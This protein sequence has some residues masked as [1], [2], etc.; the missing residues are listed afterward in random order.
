LA[1]Q[2]ETA[3]APTGEKHANLG[4]KK[5]KYVSEGHKRSRRKLFTRDGLSYV[6]R[7]D[8]KRNKGNVKHYISKH[9][10]PPYTRPLQ[11]YNTIIG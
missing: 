9:I 1:G 6:T 5:K 10:P 4:L 3:S 11:K 8:V 7:S 2:D